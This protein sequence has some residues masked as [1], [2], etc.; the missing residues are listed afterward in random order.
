MPDNLTWETFKT[1]LPEPHRIPVSLIF[2]LKHMEKAVAW[3]VAL[4]ERNEELIRRTK[5]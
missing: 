5:P 3:R 1:S 4:K 2:D